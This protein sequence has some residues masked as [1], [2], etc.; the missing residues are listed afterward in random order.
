VQDLATYLSQKDINTTIKYPKYAKSYEEVFN[1]I[2]ILDNERNH[3][4]INMSDIITSIKDL[5]VKA[6]DNRLIDNI[7]GFKDYFRKIDVQNSELLDEFE[8]RSEKY[9]QLLTDLKSVNEMI[10]LGSN[11]KCGS[12]KKN[13]VSE[14]RK[15]IKEKNYNLLMKIIATGESR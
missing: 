11:L 13:M 1:R 2:E 9:Q 12:F 8:K 7:R 5:Y 3:F 14:C 4:N 15:C 6:E 10:Q